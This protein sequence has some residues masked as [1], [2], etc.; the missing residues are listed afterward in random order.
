[1][2]RR[3]R[4]AGFHPRDIEGTIDTHNRGRRHLLGCRVDQHLSRCGRRIRIPGLVVRDDREGVLHAVLQARDLGARIARRE[5]PATIPI[6]DRVARNRA[7]VR[8]ARLETHERRSRTHRGHRHVLRRIGTVQDLH[9]DAALHDAIRV[10]RRIHD[11]VHDDHVAMEARL[12]CHRQNIPVAGG[13][14]LPHVHRRVEDDERLR[15]RV[16]RV[17]RQIHVRSLTSVDLD[18]RVRRRHEGFRGLHDRHRNIGIDRARPII[19]AD[20]DRAD[21]TLRLVLLAGHRQI[22]AVQ[23]HVDA[24]GG[25]DHGVREGTLRLIVRVVHHL[26]EIHRHGLALSH[27]DRGRGQ[28]RR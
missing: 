26:R 11:A 24:T 21:R 16:R 2:D 10:I 22:E 27:E 7:A 13:R 12:G 18:A 19:D 3:P 4:V 8:G 1:M 25:L 5:G 9:D 20:R 6:G 15:K 14:S 23:G 17:L 28:T